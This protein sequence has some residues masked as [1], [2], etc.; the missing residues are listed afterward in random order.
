[1]KNLNAALKELAD[2]INGLD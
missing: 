1:M 2:S